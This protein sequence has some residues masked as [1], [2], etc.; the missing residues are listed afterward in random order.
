MS[1]ISVDNLIKTRKMRELEAEASVAAKAHNKNQKELFMLREAE[2]LKRLRK[3][4]D[5]IKQKEILEKQRKNDRTK[6][7]LINLKNKDPETWRKKRDA[8]NEKARLDR[9]ERKRYLESLSFSDPELYALE[10]R[11]DEL[12]KD[13][14]NKTRI[15][16]RELLKIRNP[17]LHQQK[18]NEISEQR[19]NKYC[20]DPEFRLKCIAAST[21]YLK[22]RKIISSIKLEFEVKK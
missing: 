14:Y 10:I 6:L 9:I 4:Q 3:R 12:L 5:E 18:N 19:R 13:R 2:R 15:K 21:K 11:K 22:K 17:E 20:N 1:V 7:A 16:R 8:L